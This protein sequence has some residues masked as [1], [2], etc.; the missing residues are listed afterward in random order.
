MYGERARFDLAEEDGGV[1]ARV[2]I[3]WSAAP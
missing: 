1:V 2:V 3:P